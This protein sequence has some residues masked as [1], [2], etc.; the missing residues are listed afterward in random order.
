MDR[1]MAN[2]LHSSK[3]TSADTLNYFD[4]KLT[5]VPRL[6]ECSSA[7]TNLNYKIHDSVIVCCLTSQQHACV[8][9]RLICSYNYECCHTEIDVADQTF[10]LTQSQNAES[11][12]TSPSADPVIPSA[13]QGNH[14][15]VNFYVT[16]M[17][18]PT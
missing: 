5:R 13:R 11:G 6:S 7:L 12:P 18:R 17:A 8:S 4:D 16:R 1:I 9:Q 2:K 15:S 10:Y 14:W 3:G